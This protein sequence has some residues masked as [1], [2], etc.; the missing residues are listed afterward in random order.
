VIMAIVFSNRGV[1]LGRGARC[2]VRFLERE[3]AGRE[4]FLLVV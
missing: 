4:S 3:Q 2:E 1:I